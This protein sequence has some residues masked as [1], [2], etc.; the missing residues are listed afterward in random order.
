MAIVQEHEVIT[1]LIEAGDADSAA[2]A[3][4][5]HLTRAEERLLGRQDPSQDPSQA[6]ALADQ[7]SEPAPLY[8]D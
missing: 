3:L 6:D 7:P 2:Q 1:K 8:T 4:V 5:D